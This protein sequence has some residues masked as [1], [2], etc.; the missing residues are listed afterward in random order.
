MAIRNP[1]PPLEDIERGVAPPAPE[2]DASAMTPPRGARP[3]RARARRVRRERPSWPGALA[4]AFPDAVTAFAAAVPAIVA[5]L[6]SPGAL[7]FVIIA[8]VLLHVGGYVLARGLG[9]DIW[10]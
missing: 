2:P 8:L 4:V 9:L 3:D 6:R 7:P 5:P 1:L 10:R